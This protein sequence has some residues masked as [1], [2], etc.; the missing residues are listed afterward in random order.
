MVT[1]G[2]FCQQAPPARIACT[3]VDAKELP[4]TQ[5]D[6]NILF[7]RYALELSEMEFL[8]SLNI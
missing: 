5:T 7:N 3:T 6:V 2:V 8:H 1:N 4:L